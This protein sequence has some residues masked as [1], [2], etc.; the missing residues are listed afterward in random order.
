VL[1]LLAGAALAAWAY[2]VLCHGGFWRADQRLPS[3]LQTPQQWPDVTAVIPARDEAPVIGGA[4]ESLLRQD[5]PGDLR[6]FVVDDASSDG[7]ADAARAGAARAGA[8]DRLSIVSAPPLPPGWS[9]KLWAVHNGVAAAAADR[10]YVLLTDADIVHA[11]DALR[12]LVAKAESGGLDLVSLMVRLNCTSFA[13]RLLIP[14]FVLFFQKLYPFPWVNDRA[15]RMAG[16]AGGCMLG[17]R[18]ALEHA[19]GIAAVKDALID[20]CALAALLKRNG[21]IWLGLAERTVSV[22]GY[23]RITDV[24]RMVA[25]TAYTQ[26]RH[27]PWLVLGTVLGMALLYVVPPLAMVLCPFAGAWLAAALGAAAFALMLFAYR[28]TWTLYRGDDPAILLLP[29]AALLYTAMTVDSMRRHL[30]GKGGAWKGRTYARPT[31]RTGK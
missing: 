3:E 13:A 7:T 23:P 27:S 1:T 21:P 31:A 20:D 24:W 6:V 5:Y 14:A 26:L 12:R 22:R 8:D 25:R 19:G 15:K 16:A 10:R 17:R 4:V 29:L 18:A 2:L 9:G 30:L 28:P 11:P